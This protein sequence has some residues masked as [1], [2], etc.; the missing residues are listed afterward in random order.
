[1]LTDDPIAR[2]RLASVVAAMML[3]FGVLFVYVTP[4]Y[5]G[6]DETAHF[7]RVAMIAGGD[8]LPGSKD[9][10]KGIALPDSLLRFE[11]RHAAIQ[12][13]LDAKYDYKRLVGEMRAGASLRPKTF[14]TFVTQSTS[15]LMYAPSLLGVAAGSLLSA[16]SF[17]EPDAVNW[18]TMFY[19]ARLGNLFALAI[20]VAAALVLLPRFHAALAFVALMPMTMFLSASV[21]YDSMSL[22]AC[23]GLFVV[24]VRGTIRKGPLSRRELALLA[25]SAFFLGHGK[26]VYLPLLLALVPVALA[27]PR[28]DGLLAFGV[29]AGAALLGLA[30]GLLFPLLSGAPSD[31]VDQQVAFLL[32][33]LANIPG[34]VWRTLAEM[35][36]YYFRT[37]FGHFG[38]LDTAVPPSLLVLTWGVLLLALVNDSRGPVR[39]VS[40]ATR[41]AIAAGIVLSL[42]AI[43]LALYVIWTPTKP[44]G[45][46]SPIVIGVQG[47]YFIPFLPFAMMAL[48]FNLRRIAPKL[49]AALPDLLPVQLALQAAALAASL[50]F[51]LLRYWI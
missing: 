50:L 33:D 32:A 48:S 49:A 40:A 23:L 47:R 4:P 17:A 46:G 19:F 34:L 31:L 26:I 25:V 44:D 5:Q 1:M 24:V 37:L 35:H 21:Q 30:G 11:K 2:R 43:M 15:P 14:T 45:V 18:A 39:R 41:I 16:A 27:S 29:A 6:P 20:A 38:W 42:V 3:F 51:L 36:G 28:R 8:L 7:A 13:D 10:V 9:G 12:S 22:I